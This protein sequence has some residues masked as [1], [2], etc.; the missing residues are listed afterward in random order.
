MGLFV[1]SVVQSPKI[2]EFEYKC[3]NYI[4]AYCVIVRHLFNTKSLRELIYHA[5]FIE[6]YR[7]QHPIHSSSVVIPNYNI[8]SDWSEARQHLAQEFRSSMAITSDSDPHV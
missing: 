3:M 1:V 4:Q 6:Q 7:S 2:S 5:S 8:P